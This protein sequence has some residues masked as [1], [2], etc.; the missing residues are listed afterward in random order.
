MLRP[1]VRSW[2]TK[3][4]GTMKL[5]IPKIFIGLIQECDARL[6]LFHVYRHFRPNQLVYTNQPAHILFGAGRNAC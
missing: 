6:D 3:N 5:L 1:L 4:L 2:C